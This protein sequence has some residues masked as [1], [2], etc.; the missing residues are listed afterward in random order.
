MYILK[1]LLLNSFNEFSNGIYY[2]Y[3]FFLKNKNYFKIYV[4]C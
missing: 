3:F 1:Y 4:L 2:Y